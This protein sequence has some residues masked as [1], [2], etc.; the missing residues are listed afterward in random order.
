MSFGVKSKEIFIQ[1]PQ[2]VAR[3]VK[4]DSHDLAVKIVAIAVKHP[5]KFILG[6][7]VEIWLVSLAFHHLKEAK[8]IM[9]ILL[10][11]K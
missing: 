1:R 9:D 10:P 5:T 8:E 11:W 7:L 6:I 4:D 3:Y 2:G